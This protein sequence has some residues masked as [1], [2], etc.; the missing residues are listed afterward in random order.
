LLEE[1]DGQILGWD[2][3]IV[4]TDVNRSFLARAGE[5]RFEDW[6]FRGV[7]EE[8]KRRYFRRAGKSWLIAEELKKRVS[9]QYHNLVRHTFPSLLNNLCNFDLIVCRN[10]MI[11]FDA[12][13]AATILAGFRQSLAEQGWLVIGHAESGLE[14][15]G[16]LRAVS[17]PGTLLYQKALPAERPAPEPT[18]W[19]RASW[20]Q[21][22]GNGMTNGPAA[23]LPAAAWLPAGPGPALEPEPPAPARFTAPPEVAAAPAGPSAAEEPALETLRRLADRGQWRQAAGECRRLIEKDQLDPLA[24]FYNALILEQSGAA[25]EAEQA[26]RRAIYLE[27]KFVLAHYHLGLLQQRNREPDQAA[28]SFQNVVELLSQREA[29]RVFTEAD[30]ITGAELRELAKAHLEV[31][32]S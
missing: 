18:A 29:G 32:R 4:G 8:F 31:L 1:F 20:P 14:S 28:R 19:P 30:G 15:L 22:E 6:A 25:A 17:A 13:V 9:F 10:V 12:S 3:G 16:D 21:R 23:G 26:L 11:Y 5:G 27:R 7:S 24:H 2:V